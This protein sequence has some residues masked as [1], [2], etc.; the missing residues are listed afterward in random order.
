[1]VKKSACQKTKKQEKKKSACLPINTGSISGSGRSPGEGNG[2]PLQYYCPG[3]PMDRRSLVGYSPWGCTR[4][5]NNLVTKQQQYSLCV[6]AFCLSI[7][8]LMNTWVVS[9]FRFVNNAAVNIDVQV[10]I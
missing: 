2:N 6:H 7:H 9:T 10:S 1:M 5:G 4:V 3:N 8:V